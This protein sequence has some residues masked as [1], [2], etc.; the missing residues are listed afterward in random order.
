MIKDISSILRKE[1]VFDRAKY[2]VG[3]EDIK[4][5]VKK[6]ITDYNNTANQRK[7]KIDS[8]VERG[9]NRKKSLSDLL[10]KGGKGRTTKGGISG[11][12]NDS[13]TLPSSYRVKKMANF[14]RKN[15]R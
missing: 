11:S 9:E 3:P 12:Y 2:S 4:S 1:D 10:K 6:V 15:F 5:T 13:T 14:R 7:Q 8:I